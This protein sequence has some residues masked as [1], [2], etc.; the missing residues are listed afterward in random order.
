MLPEISLSVAWWKANSKK[1]EKYAGE[2]V[3]VGPEGVLAHGKSFKKVAKKAGKTK[4]TDIFYGSVA[5]KGPFVGGGLLN[6]D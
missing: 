3:A 6:W 5:P 1:L 2:W 4:E